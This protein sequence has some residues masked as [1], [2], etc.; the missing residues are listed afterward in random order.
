MLWAPARVRGLGW[1]AFVMLGIACI[2][3]PSTTQPRAAELPAP[4]SR[5]ARTA[6]VDG[7]HLVDFVRGQASSQA[8]PKGSVIA[9]G[10]PQKSPS[11][12][13]A[14]F[15]LDL[16]TGKALSRRENVMNA[17]THIERDGDTIHLFSMKSARP[18]WL[19]TD[20]ALAETG[21]VTIEG[22]PTRFDSAP[23]FSVMV[24][25]GQPIIIA[26]NPVSVH[27]IS[28]EGK[29]F[30]SHSCK[31][32]GHVEPNRIEI[33]R[34]DDTLLLKDLNLSSGSEAAEETQM[35][36]TVRVDGRGPVLR[37]TIKG[38]PRCDA[39][40]KSCEKRDRKELPCAGVGGG[41]I[42]RSET[43]YGVRVIR[44]A[45]CCGDVAKPG[46]SLCDL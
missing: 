24:V 39:D 38:D 36:C 22:L 21:R 2:V 35:T 4:A 43:I 11:G 37:K 6:S 26:G 9:L 46:L 40:P 44:N 20:L 25:A 18:L 8:L 19:K 3:Q 23:L 1:R 16:A 7:Y 28:A 42:R 13:A 10:R 12:S 29:R 45:S 31:G 30:A 17:A 34:V 5:Q 32:A 14:L 27:F 41:F 33:E 15:D